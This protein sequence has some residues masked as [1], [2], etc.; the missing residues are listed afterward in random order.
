MPIDCRLLVDDD[1]WCFQQC[2]FESS[3]SGGD[4]G[5]TRCSECFARLTA[6]YSYRLYTPVVARHDLPGLLDCSA[7]RHNNN[8]LN[9]RTMPTN[10]LYGIEHRRQ[11]SL[12]FLV[13]TAGKKR[14]DGPGGVEI[15]SPAKLLPPKTCHHFSRERVSHEFDMLHALSLVPISLERQD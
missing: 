10:L 12:E 13:P 3:G 9:T 1:H 15:V 6:N 8:K 4:S 7:R 2:S 14:D 5:R 11:N